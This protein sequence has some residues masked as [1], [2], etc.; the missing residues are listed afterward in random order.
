M[1]PSC[2]QCHTRVVFAEH[3][4]LF[5][6]KCSA[7]GWHEEGTCSSDLYPVIPTQVLVAKADP[8]I[9]ATAL[10]VIRELLP[11]AG[12]QSIEALRNQLTS[13]DGLWIGNV[14]QY[15]IDEILPR[16]SVVGIRLERPTHEEDV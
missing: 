2:P 4:G 16:F 8:P 7:C 12:T 5:S 6:I 13:Q 15:R 9:S 11:F 1:K 3:G 14:P 10:K